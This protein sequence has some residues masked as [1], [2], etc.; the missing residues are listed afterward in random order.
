M[1][2]NKYKITAVLFL[3][4]IFWI[5]TVTLWNNRTE[6]K[7]MLHSGDVINERYT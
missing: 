1:K 7:N 3:V 6:F 5:G 2:I 4:I